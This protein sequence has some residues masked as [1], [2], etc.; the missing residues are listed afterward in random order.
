MIAQFFQ[1]LEIPGCMIQ[2]GTE[3][4]VTLA[5]ERVTEAEIQTFLKSWVSNNVYFL[6]GVNAS[7]PGVKFSRAS[8]KDI[9]KKNYFYIDLDIRK[10][11]PTITDEQ[12]KTMIW[13]QWAKEC[14]QSMGGVFANWR[15]V[16]FTGN[17]LHIYYFGDAIEIESK[18]NWR[19]GINDFLDRIEASF[20]EKFDRACSNPARIARIPGS[21]NCKT[22]PF[23]KVEII[24]FQDKKIDLTVLP[25]SGEIS[26]KKA[27]AE[28]L[29]KAAEIKKQHPDSTDCYNE[30]EKIPASKVMCMLTG[31]VLSSDGKN[32]SEPGK[33]NR[34]GCFYSADKNSIIHT[35]SDHLTPSK[36][37]YRPYELVKEFKKYD[38]FQTFLWFR[39]NFPHIKKMAEEREAGVTVAVDSDYSMSSVF[40]ELRTSEIHQ[41]HLGGHWDEWRL[42]LRGKV[43]RI[44]AMPGTGKSKLG[45]F[46][47]DKLLRKE[48]RGLF[49]STEVSS[50]DVLANMLQIRMKRP[51]LDI[52]EHRVDVPVEMEQDFNNI[53]VYDVRHTGNQLTRMENI[54]KQ[55]NT[56]NGRGI[57]FIVLDWSQQVTP[58]SGKYTDIFSWATEWGNQCQEIAQKY[59][60]CF[61]DICQLSIKGNKDEDEKFGHVPYEGG[62]KLVQTADI[63]T[64]IT[65]DK[66]LSQN[67]QVI[68]DVR[69]S[70]AMGRRFRLDMEYDWTSGTFDLASAQDSRVEQG[71]P[72]GGMISYRSN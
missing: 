39:S 49:F 67:N 8:D 55:Q 6:S 52:L 44:G 53:K 59:D 14:L 16:V 31:W 58:K 12:I 19:A 70:K 60:I 71:D 10:T 48:Y 65:R 38:N 15:Y 7:M 36:T 11:Q 1:E 66:S 26:L 72:F 28:A 63:A 34:K 4:S 18:D 43:T 42:L 9:Y 33:Q 32:F 64:M 35:G 13:E 61:I 46:L 57:D 3:K 47:A 56:V 29:V 54:I 17:G 68:W 62:N 50:A 69:K 51:Y 2:F 21:E 25:R 24:D 37:G 20:N 27:A 45:Y 22:K 41:L 23:K 5:Q 40:K 30:I